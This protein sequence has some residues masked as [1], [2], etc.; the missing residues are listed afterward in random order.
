VASGTY[1]NSCSIPQ[2]KYSHGSLQVIP[3]SSIAASG[4]LVSGKPR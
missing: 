4:A 3:A 1:S 2:P